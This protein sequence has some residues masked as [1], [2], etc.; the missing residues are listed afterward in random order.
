[1]CWQREYNILHPWW[2]G[3]LGSDSHRSCSANEYQ[4]HC[5]VLLQGCSILLV[6]TYFCNL[7]FHYNALLILPKM[8]LFLCCCKHQQYLQQWSFYFSG[9]HRVGWNCWSLP[10]VWRSAWCNIL[11]SSTWRLQT[12]LVCLNWFTCKS[13]ISIQSW[14]LIMQIKNPLFSLFGV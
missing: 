1:M 3:V 9:L 11:C 7:A 10:H 6:C 5:T 14:L 2:S 12:T 4:T 8:T 13:A